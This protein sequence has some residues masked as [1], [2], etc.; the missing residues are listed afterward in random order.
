MFSRV[1][2]R[3]VKVRL[4]VGVC[5]VVLAG[6]AGVLWELRGIAANSADGDPAQ[7]SYLQDPDAADRA[8]EAV[9]AGPAREVPPQRASKQETA[10]GVPAGGGP[11]PGGVL[12]KNTTPE[13]DG[14]GWGWGGGG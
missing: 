13:P 9:L 1:R 10:P 12:T 3:A 8:A 7:G 11:G 4:L 5:C 2:G 6:G 14:S